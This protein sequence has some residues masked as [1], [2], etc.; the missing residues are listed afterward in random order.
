MYLKLSVRNALRSGR[1]YLIYTV[2]L[3]VLTA[4]MAL[5]GL[6]SAAGGRA[7]LETA[8]LPLLVTL[9]M[10]VLMRYVNRF[11]LRQ[12]AREFACYLLLGMG[13]GQLAGMFFLE[14]F[15]MGCTC[16]AVGTPLGLGLGALLFSLLLP[17]GTAVAAQSALHAAAETGGYFLVISLLSLLGTAGMIRRL[18]IRELMQEERRNL[19]P[20]RGTG[21]GWAAVAAASALLLAAMLAGIA[22]LPDGSGNALVSLVSL[23]LLTLAVSFYRA[24]YALGSAYRRAGRLLA[25]DRLYLAGQYLAGGASGAVMNSVLFL[26]LVFCAAAFLFGGVMLAPGHVWMEP[27]MQR[28]MGFLQLCICVIF[29]VLYFAVLSL[30]RV[31]EVQRERRGIRILRRLGKSEGQIRRLLAKQIGLAFSTPLALFFPLL[32]ATVPLVGDKM[33]EPLLLWR[34][35]GV[36]LAGFAALYGAYG[37]AAFRMSA[38]AVRE[39]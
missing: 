35:C 15:L 24:V 7:G 12:R 14:S 6:V 9:I 32:A 28:W 17:G 4:V 1:D 16:F 21:R 18:E 34:L 13:R 11:I 36:F 30:R 23:P 25:G 38:R 27:G 2:T 26:C 33:G 39:P 31:V 3:T 20:G 8:S 19:S 5:S 37:W 29:G 22:L 10:A